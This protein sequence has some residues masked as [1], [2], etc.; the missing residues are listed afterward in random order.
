VGLH[1]EYAGERIQYGILC[2]FS[3]F[4]EYGHLEHVH[5]NVIYRIHQAEYGIHILVAASQEFVNTYSKRRVLGHLRH[6]ELRGRRVAPP[7]PPTPPRYRH[8]VNLSICMRI[9]VGVS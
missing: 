4:Y 1:V 7:S 5:I 8:W 9:D 6:G 2:I 3:L